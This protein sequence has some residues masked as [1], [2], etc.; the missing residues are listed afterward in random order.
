M[1]EKTFEKTSADC[2][3]NRTP[4]RDF[5]RVFFIKEISERSSLCRTLLKDF[6]YSENL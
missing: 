2:F 1:E 3:L 6:I 5:C 4:L